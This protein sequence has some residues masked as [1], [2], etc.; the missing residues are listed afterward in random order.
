VVT[1]LS[2]SFEMVLWR[3]RVVTKTTTMVASSAS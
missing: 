3:Y 1:N 2:T